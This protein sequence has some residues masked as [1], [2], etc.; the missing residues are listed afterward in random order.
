L[1]HYFCLWLAFRTNH[2]SWPA[3]WTI[4]IA[5]NVLLPIAMYRLIEYPMIRL[6]TKLSTA[7]SAAVH[8]VQERVQSC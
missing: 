4:F 3:Q 7:P 2:F 8:L 1:A 6:G 5:T